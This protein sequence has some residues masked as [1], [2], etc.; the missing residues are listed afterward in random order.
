MLLFQRRIF[1]TSYFLALTL[2]LL[3]KASPKIIGIFYLMIALF[4]H[5]FS[6]DILNKNK[7]YYY[8]NLGISKTK[9]WV[10]TILIG[11]INL[12]ILSLI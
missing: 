12:F 1:F 7:Y 10:S 5:L 3:I 9:L 6:Y 4:V 2:A 11:F 8:F